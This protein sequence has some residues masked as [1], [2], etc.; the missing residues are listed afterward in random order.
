M[1][2]IV[3]RALKSEKPLFSISLYYS[4]EDMIS[5]WFIETFLRS[6]KHGKHAGTGIKFILLCHLNFAFLKFENE[7]GMIIWILL[8]AWLR[9]I[10]IATFLIVKLK[11]KYVFLCM[12]YYSNIHCA[13]NLVRLFLKQKGSVNFSKWIKL[14][15]HA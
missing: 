8:R 1:K 13:F 12:F 4:E 11:F 6:W 7:A 2:Y 5:I 9:W 15:F 10:T 3:D 14:F